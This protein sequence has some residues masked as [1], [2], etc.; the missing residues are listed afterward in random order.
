MNI[1]AAATENCKIAKPISKCLAVKASI[2]WAIILGINILIA[3][4]ARAIIINKITIPEYG[5]NK[6]NIPG[7][8]IVP[9]ADRIIV[10]P[11]FIAILYKGI[12]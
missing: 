4:P 12:Q 3:L 5:F 11:I 9:L 7:L 8:G 6:L 2:V 1:A 10:F